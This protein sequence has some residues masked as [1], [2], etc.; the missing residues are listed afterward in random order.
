[1]TYTILVVDDNEMNLSLMSKILELEGYQ[2]RLAYTGIEAIQSVIQKMPDMA[3]LDIMMP[4]M[5]GLELCRRLRQPPLNVT[6]PI[7][8]LS[9]MNAETE[10]ELVVEA[11]ANDM[12]AKPFDLEVF[13]RRVGELLKPTHPS[14]NP[15][16]K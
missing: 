10:R 8:L 13:R 7:V 6:V 5:N 14:G 2:V 1:M 15:Q 3:I 4:D 12:W 9:A 11:G 16:G